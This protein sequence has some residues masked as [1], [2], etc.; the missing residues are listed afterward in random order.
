MGTKGTIQLP[1]AFRADENNYDGIIHYQSS[2]ETQ[3]FKEK[4]NA[5][6]EQIKAFHQAIEHK[7]SPAYTHAQMLQQTETM[8]RIAKVL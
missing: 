4:G 8:E 1:Y 6:I 7:E 3:T 2:N 5:Y